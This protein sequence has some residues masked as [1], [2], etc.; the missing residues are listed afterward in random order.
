M[1]NVLYTT[2]SKRGGGIKS[3]R[4]TI[5]CSRKETLVLE[6]T[7]IERERERERES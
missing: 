3:R 4:R 7:I 2:G 1:S 5:S 6:I